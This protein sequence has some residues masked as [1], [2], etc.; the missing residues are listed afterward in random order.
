[1]KSCCNKA[2]VIQKL[3][4]DYDRAN[5]S[6]HRAFMQ[7]QI[8]LASAHY[9]RAFIISTRIL[10][11]SPPSERVFQLSINA[12]LNCFDFCPAPNDNDD[13]HYLAVTGR[14]LQ[15]IISQQQDNMLRA[16]ALSAYAEVYRLSHFLIKH[17]HCKQA[18]TVAAEFKTCWALHSSLLMQ[19]H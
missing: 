15:R 4:A 17:D 1:M 3:Q 7:G 5:L 6:A 8:D 10:S 14:A 16:A 13:Y 11:S 9:Q 12:C 19:F 18:A 2:T